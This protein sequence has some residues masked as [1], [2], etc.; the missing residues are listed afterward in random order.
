MIVG[1]GTDFF[2]TAIFISPLNSSLIDSHFL[3]QLPKFLPFIFTILGIVCAFILYSK[4]QS[5]L[6]SLKVSF[7]GL[8]LYRFLNK[9]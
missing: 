8:S 5:M 4:H 7:L 1:V 3:P 9:K 6:Y 2:S